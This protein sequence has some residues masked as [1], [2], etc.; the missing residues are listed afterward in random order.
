MTTPALLEEVLKHLKEYTNRITIVESDSGGYNRFSMDEVFDRTGIRT[1]A[2]RLG[3]GIV[4]LSHE[5]AR[6]VPVETKL[7]RLSVPLPTLLLD[8]TDHFVTMPVPKIH[9]NTKVSAGIKN[10]WGVIQNPADRLKLHPYFKYVIHAV[11]KALP[12]PLTIVDGTFGLSRSGPLRGDAIALNWLMLSDNLYYGD[13]AVCEL[14]GIA[15]RKVPYLRYIFA[16]EGVRDLKTVEM[17]DDL[18]RF[19][20]HRFHLN[21]AVTDYPGLL[22]FKSR[23]LAY[24]G[25]ES[26][27]AGPL[28][29]LLYL[30]REPFF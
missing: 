24:V 21:R 4:N 16:K 13:Y 2:S 27:L 29:R 17:N 15:S 23:V 1:S 19:K 22:T 30:F 9:M 26:P 25:Y 12:R 20:G 14:M 3:I 18:D 10:Q 7:R 28:H 6:P 8:H 5:P 11:N